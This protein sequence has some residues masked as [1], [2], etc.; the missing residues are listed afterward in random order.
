LVTAQLVK[1]PSVV[2][3]HRK[4]LA[5]DRN[6]W[7][8]PL[9]FQGLGTAA[10]RTL[11]REEHDLSTVVEKQKWETPVWASVTIYGW[12]RGDKRVALADTS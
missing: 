3:V 11:R 10:T 5:C 4:Q 12:H 9:I 6:L 7:P 1:E 8:R 2:T